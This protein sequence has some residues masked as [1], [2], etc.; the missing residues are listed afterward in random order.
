MTEDEIIAHFNEKKRLP[1]VKSL[2]Q[3]L[4]DYKDRKCALDFQVI[5]LLLFIFIY[6]D[7]YYPD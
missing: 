1:V 3:F 7:Y 6:Y 4:D 2:E 5:I